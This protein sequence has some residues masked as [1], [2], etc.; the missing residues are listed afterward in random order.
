MDEFHPDVETGEQVSQT[1]SWVIGRPALA[2]AA[3][4]TSSRETRDLQDAT[5]A[6][7]DWQ[8]RG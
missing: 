6:R 7:K 2:G 4:T 1:S 8:K 3:A 5:N